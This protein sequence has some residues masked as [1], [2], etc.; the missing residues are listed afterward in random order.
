VPTSPNAP[1]IVIPDGSVRIH[2]FPRQRPAR[3]FVSETFDNDRL[4]IAYFRRAGEPVL[5]GRVWFGPGSEGPPGYAHGGAVAAVLDESLGGVAW[6]LGHRVVVARLTVDFRNMVALGLD[7][8]LE[9]RVVSIDGRKI[10]CRAQLADAGIL[11]AE[12]D[13]LCVVLKEGPGMP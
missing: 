11:L 5:R 6:M 2:P 8:T 13:G 7:A 12:A 9:A 4:R 10:T 3:S 1:P